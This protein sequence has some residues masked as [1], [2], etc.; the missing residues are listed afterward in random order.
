MHI[1]TYIHKYLN[2]STYI[3]MYCICVYVDVWICLLLES[4]YYS[5]LS[6]FQLL[7]LTQAATADRMW[8]NLRC[9]W[10]Y[11]RAAPAFRV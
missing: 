11:C 2:I 8:W 5:H 7:A 9:E 10:Q 3:C 1:H 6:L 4:R